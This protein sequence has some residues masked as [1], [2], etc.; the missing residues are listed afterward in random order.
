MPESRAALPKNIWIGCESPMG[1]HIL[2]SCS[3]LVNRCLC[4]WMIGIQ[5]ANGVHEFLNCNRRVIDLS[6]C[7][8]IGDGPRGTTLQAIDIYAGVEQKVGARLGSA[9]TY[10][11]SPSFR[12][13]KVFLGSN[14]AQR[15]A[16]SK[17]NSAKSE[18]SLIDANTYV[19]STASP[20]I[21]QRANRVA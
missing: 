5:H 8:H 13:L 20:S 12:R 9:P 10:G 15:T 14:R 21:Y 7:K 16:A 19:S 3:D 4:A 6:E 17:S 11:R 1:R 18:S 2:H